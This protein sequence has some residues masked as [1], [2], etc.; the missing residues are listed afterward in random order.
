MEPD[1]QTFGALVSAT[2]RQD[3]LAM[4]KLVHAHILTSG[5][6]LDTPVETLLIVMY[7]KYGN[8]DEAYTI[9]EQTSDKDTILWTTMISGLVQN[10]C[11]D[12]AISLFKRMLIS[13]VMPS[14]A[15][16]ASALAACAH[17]GSFNLGT[18]IHG[19]IIRQRLPVDIPTQN[20]LVS[21]YSKCGHLEQS[22]ILFNMM[23]KRDVV[24]WNAIVSG[25]AQNGNLC[26]AMCLFNEMRIA[27][28]R[29]DS[30]TVVSLLQACA[31]IGAYHQGKWIHSF[32]IRSCLGSCI[33][34]DTT[35]VDMYSKCG[36]L[37]NAR[38]CF[39]RM[40]QHDLVSWSTIIAGYGS[41]GKGETALEMYVEFLKAGLKPTM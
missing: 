16:I 41:H 30:I 26:K 37:N 34:V 32:V 27:L 5:F 36:N 35:L 21:M 33:L 7:L 9:F 1:Q 8:L 13:K 15:T 14:T 10:E 18:S 24:S 31:S 40:L 4:G 28:E 23:D 20:S 17:L 2:A 19:Y 11:A 38:K 22:C 29:P 12:K 25:H 6:E 39:D 3:N